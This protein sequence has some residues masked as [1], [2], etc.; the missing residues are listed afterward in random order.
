VDRQRADEVLCGL[1]RGDAGRPG[2]GSTEALSS[3]DWQDI[4]RRARALKV[5]PYL[6]GRLWA[7]PPGGNEV[8]EDAAARLRRD[9][10][11][12]AGRNARL[13][14]ELGGLLDRLNREGIRVIVL[15]GGHLAH[16]VYGNIGLRTM[17]DLD[18]LV[19]TEDLDRGL[20]CMEAAGCLSGTSGVNL[21]VQT[22]I[23]YTI[24]GLSVPVE[25]LLERAR[26]FSVAGREAWGLCPED[27]LLHLVLHLAVSDLFGISGLRGLCDIRETVARVGPE[28][29]WEAVAARA[30]AWSAGNRRG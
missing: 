17:S 22:T 27:L 23:S 1:I 12:N 14:H 9:Y 18:L 30:V 6:H 4:V 24:A 19:R 2:P 26:P 8:P 25:D 15:K 29:D 10:L 11:L 20:R 13:F 21:D 28:L 16:E 3:G 5:A 7:A